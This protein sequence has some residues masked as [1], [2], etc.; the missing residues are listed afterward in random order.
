MLKKI[1]ILLLLQVGIYN[2]YAQNVQRL[3]TNPS[4]KG[5]SIGM[6]ISSIA[7]E[8]TYENSVNGFTLY[9]TTAASYCSVF[10]VRM[11]FVRVVAKNGKVH[12]IDAVRI[13]KATKDHP[14][15]FNA[16]DLE[17]LKAGLTSQYG[18]PTHGLRKD[19][20]QYNRFG[21]QWQANSKQV[22]CFMDFYGT[23][24]GYKLQYSLSEFSLDY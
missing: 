9:Q 11:N 16:D 14:T 17:V 19:T 12:A 7:D 1:F 20:D 2:M 18:E 13:V 10:N 21:Y 3:E 15:I 8:L 23:F 22:C 6:P 24:Q 5:I 4:F